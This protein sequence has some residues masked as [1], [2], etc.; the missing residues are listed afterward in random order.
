MQIFPDVSQLI[1]VLSQ[2][3]C[4]YQ[5]GPFQLQTDSRRTSSDC[6]FITLLMH[7]SCFEDDTWLHVKLVMFNIYS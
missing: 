7:Q 2:F 5:F 6:R 3:A 1:A 4:H